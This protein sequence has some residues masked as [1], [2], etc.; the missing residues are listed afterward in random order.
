MFKYCL[1]LFAIALGISDSAIPTDAILAADVFRSGDRI[2][3][4]GEAE[5]SKVVVAI[6]RISYRK[7]LGTKCKTVTFNTNS[8]PDL[9]QIDGKTINPKPFP[10]KPYKKCSPKIPRSESYRSGNRY[11]VNSSALVENKAYLI[12][13]IKPKTKSIKTNRCGFG[14]FKLVETLTAFSSSFEINIYSIKGVKL[15]EMPDR[16]KPTCP[17]KKKGE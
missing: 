10:N 7:E 11:V 13:I 1:V 17:R 12:R 16:E 3:I 5:N 2:Y 14:S 8:V 15:S 6:Q 4:T 9:I